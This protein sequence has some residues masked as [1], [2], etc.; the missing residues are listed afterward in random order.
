ME[1]SSKKSNIFSTLFFVGVILGLLF[2]IP[3]KKELVNQELTADKELKMVFSDY[4]P[5]AK[6]VVVYDLETEEKIFSFNEQDQLPL[7]SLTKIMTIVVALENI[8]PETIISINRKEADYLI[9]ES[10]ENL[11]V[12]YITGRKWKVGDVA[13]MG[14]LS[15]MNGNMAA[16]ATMSLRG[17]G[18]L[19]E[20]L[21]NRLDFV[22]TM[23][24]KARLLGLNSLQFFNESGLDTS[25]DIAGGYGSALDVARLLGYA[26]KKYPH[27]FDVT[28]ENDLNFFDLD[29]KVENIKNTNPHVK[30]IKGIIA[31][32]TGLTDL[33]GGNLA[34]IVDVDLN[35]WIA[36]VV[37]GSTEDDR[38]KEV[39]TL[40]DKTV[41]YFYNKNLK[42][43]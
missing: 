15:S 20:D 30:K 18:E 25:K 32:K 1:I 5:A 17:G 2:F 10:V 26:V 33:A 40:A 39:A 37:L 3:E 24:N 12:N 28:R 13:K 19:D 6:S 29:G 23:N 16:L 34:V 41:K 31:S 21:D 42:H 7:A 35:H 43:K 8:S 9:K 11:D 22:T 14:L 36:I 27:I 4:L 38:F